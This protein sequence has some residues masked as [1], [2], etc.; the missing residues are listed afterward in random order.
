[1]NEK[2]CLHAVRRSRLFENVPAGVI[3]SSVLPHGRCIP[4]AQG[5][6]VFMPLD[7]VSSVQLLLSGRIKLVYYMENGE[8]DV[9]NM[10]FPPNLVG[11]DLIC[12][13]TQLSPYQAI[14]AE[15]SELFSFPADILLQPGAM[16]ERERLIC[17]GNLLQIISHINMQNEYRL[18]ILTRSSLR[19]R[20]L[21]YLTMQAN[22]TQSNTFRIP[23]SREEMASYL[24]VNRSALSHELSLLRQEGII[25]FSKNVFTLRASGLP[26]SAAPALF[27]NP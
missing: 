22:R 19:E 15:Q 10:L 20:I 18:A 26:G 2:E 11:V 17:L 3:E 21:V 4:F 27:T 25:N 8:E 12:T 13:R 1:M 23:F 24:R 14:A 16:P 9:R 5:A 6:N 7:R